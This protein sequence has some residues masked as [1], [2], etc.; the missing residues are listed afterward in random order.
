MWFNVIQS[1]VIIVAVV[2]GVRLVATKQKRWVKVGLVLIALAVAY[3][4][5]RF[6]ELAFMV[7]IM[8]VVALGGSALLIYLEETR[9][10]ARSQRIRQDLK[11]HNDLNCFDGCKALHCPCSHHGYNKR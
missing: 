3:F 11:R 5:F 1:M 10:K 2:V 4:A 7:V 6:N 9:R 8:S